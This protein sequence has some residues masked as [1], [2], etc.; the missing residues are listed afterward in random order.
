M[1][2]RIKSVPPEMVKK[3]VG[4]FSRKHLHTL[5]TSELSLDPHILQRYC[6]WFVGGDFT[7]RSTWDG[8]RWG[9]PRFRGQEKPTW[10]EAANARLSIAQL[11]CHLGGA[12]S[13]GNK[14]YTLHTACKRGAGSFNWTPYVAIDLDDKGTSCQP[15]QARY[16]MCVRAFGAPLV[17]RSS[18]GRGLH[19]YWPLTAP[20]SVFGLTTTNRQDESLIQQRL[21][22]EGLNITPGNAE[23]FPHP[24]RTLC[25]PVPSNVLLDPAPLHPL[26][27]SG[28]AEC[29]RRI[30]ETIESLSQS[31]P[32]DPSAL[33]TLPASSQ[34]AQSPPRNSRRR[35]RTSGAP[36]VARLLRGG[37][38]DGI[39]RNQACMA[40]ARHWMVVRR[41]GRAETIAALM[42]WTENQCNGLSKT[43]ERLHERAAQRE[44][45][46]EY[47]RICRGIEAGLANG[48]VRHPSV[49]G[50]LFLTPEETRRAFEAS[51]D[52]G[53]RLQYLQEVFAWCLIGFAKRQ[54]KEGSMPGRVHVE[55][56]ISLVQGWPGC[57]GT[58]Y[59]RRMHWAI[60][61]GLCHLVKRHRPPRNGR[62]GRARTYEVP[63]D[64]FGRSVLQIDDSALQKSV[65]STSKSRSRVHPQQIEHALAVHSQFKNLRERYGRRQAERIQR[66]VHAYQTAL[67]ALKQAA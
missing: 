43:A 49:A 53:G 6:W 34:S 59:R 38:Y 20:M 62:R 26:S 12:E 11:G 23:I 46:K 10:G 48:V 5:A 32:L 35:T 67:R 45:S 29:I 18:G 24:R 65:V 2:D 1:S 39:S 37:L 52:T 51:A 50:D 25:L 40:L 14:R 22:A 15:L 27:A 31:A 21:R 13:A 42:D 9:R 55:L 66:L 47:D 19:L 63:I 56:A 33:V 57:A 8:V 60:R 7:W 44:L 30:V 28:S 61:R 16:E 17:L 36:D 41:Y 54:G 58:Q 64:V 3:E 4:R